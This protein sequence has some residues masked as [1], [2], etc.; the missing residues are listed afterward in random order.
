MKSFSVTD[1]GRKRK[2]NQDYEFASDKAVGVLPNLYFVADGMGGHKAGDY[3]SRFT[4]NE[5]VRKIRAGE[6]GAQI[7]LRADD[8]ND[9]VGT[10]LREVNQALYARAIED[11][12]LDGCGT[13]TVTCVLKMDEGANE[14]TAYISNV[15]DSRLYVAGTQMNQITVDH[16]LVQEMIKAGSLDKASARTHPEKNVITRA[17][18]VEDFVDIDF[19]ETKVRPG[20][21]ILLC[22]DGLTNMVED[23]EILPVLRG[24]GTL[25]DKAK[26]LVKMANDNGGTDNIT[27]LLIDPFH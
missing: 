4:V 5:L 25:E 23:E 17:V 7:P 11:E 8:P 3:A 2:M 14:A 16:S 26:K 21:I 13:T 20:D 22:T 6:T 1:I 27:V 24:G 15:G 18:G 12:M 19:F 9:V 10:M